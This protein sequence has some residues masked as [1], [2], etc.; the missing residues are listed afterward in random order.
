M[1]LSKPCS[2]VPVASQ[3][4]VTVPNTL[5][6]LLTLSQWLEQV[7]LAL[8]LSARALFRLQLAAEEAVTNIIQNAYGDDRSHEI[9]VCLSQVDRHLTLRIQD[10][11]LSF[12][13]LQYANQSFPMTLEAAQKGGMGLHLIRHFSDEC[14]Y[15]RRG[16]FNVLEVVLE[17]GLEVD[18]DSSG[19]VC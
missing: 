3:Y 19:A 4:Q 7:A 17:E 10:D 14:R 2:S 1:L 15:Q 16:E 9:Q 18:R 12:N 11:G 8:N 6:S 13:P 5:D